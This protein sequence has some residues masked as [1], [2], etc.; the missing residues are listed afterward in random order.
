MEQTPASS[1]LNRIATPHTPKDFKEAWDTALHLLSEWSE[2]EADPKPKGEVDHFWHSKALRGLVHLD[3]INKRECPHWVRMD[4]PIR[5]S[6]SFTVIYDQVFD[7]PSIS[8][9]TGSCREL[10]CSTCFS[11]W[12]AA[13]SCRGGVSL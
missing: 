7:S 2:Q 9:K 1:L 11:R 3:P 13:G 12:V 8:N 4:S 6:G 10:M 5:V